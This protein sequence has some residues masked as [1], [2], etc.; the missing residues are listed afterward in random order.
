M[1]PAPI[2][3]ILSL[4]FTDLVEST[5]L[6]A[7]RGDGPAAELIARHRE[8][9][10]RMAGEN[11]G[12]IVDTAGDGCFLVFETPSAAVTFALALQRAHAA[13]PELPLVRVGVHL[14]EVSEAVGAGGALRVEGMAV[15]LAARVQSLAMPGQ[16]LLTA[17]VAASARQRLGPDHAG[18]P[19]VW[20]A[21]GAYALKGAAEPAE[22]H[23]VGLAGS[24]PLVAP[25]GTEKARSLRRGRRRALAAASLAAVGVALA[26][27]FAL[28][29]RATGRTGAALPPIRSVA[30]LPLANLSGDRQQDYFADGM[31]ESLTTELAKLPGLKVTSRTSVLQYDGTRLSLPEIAREL[32]VDGILEGSVMRAG[33]QVRI[34]T[35]LIDARSDT[36]IW[37]E[38]YDRDLSRVLEL[39]SDVARAVAEKIR[40]TLTPQQVERLAL[41]RTI[42]PRA[43]EAYFRGLAERSQS[44]FPSIERSVPL[45]EEA[46]RIEPDY[47]P[48]HAALSLSYVFLAAEN[49]GA[50]E[51]EK[52]RRAALR[53]IEL[54]EQLG[55]GH[56]ALARILFRYDWDWQA[57]EREGWR[58]IALPRS[59][60]GIRGGELAHV[61]WVLGRRSEALSVFDRLVEEVPHSAVMRAARGRFIA[62]AG[63]PERGLRELESALAIDSDVGI[64]WAGLQE[65]N[66]QLGW[67]DEAVNAL[68]REAEQSRRVDAKQKTLML[69][70][71]EQLS[72][73][74]RREGAPG[75]WKLFL[76]EAERD[77][78]HFGAAQMY[79]LLGDRE[80]ALANLE[81]ACER[82]EP[83]SRFFA[84]EWKLASLRGEPRFRELAR[85]MG[86][87]IPNTP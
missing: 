43:Q 61:L 83:T 72:D 32:G 62:W 15:D 64:G 47:A 24:A 74:L 7:A 79:A 13:A 84:V 35:Q 40:L 57:A 78:D 2:S 10:A 77:A 70:A 55:D 30:V 5:A 56:L 76:R 80:R 69:D 65:A 85:R 22:I 48:A 86:L 14:G 23:E 3:R 20:R 8:L 36:H 71:A 39:Q 67:L 21:H 41:R 9:V 68:R 73:A 42:D 50:P 75:Y 29:E 16:I 25:A 31:T 28:R 60:P 87:P 45:F 82:R 4:V 44:T 54:D 59:D 19:V 18:S 1:A 81:L 27:G 63:E 6:K 38:S 53:A 17:P 49:R 26:A 52:G 51:I 33:D 11:G 58:A 34:T 46:I 66:E 37:A 12:R